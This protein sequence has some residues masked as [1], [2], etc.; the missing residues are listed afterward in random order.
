MGPYSAGHTDRIG[1][2]RCFS[3]QRDRLSAKEH[4]HGLDPFANRTPGKRAVSDCD[5][6]FGVAIQ[7]KPAAVENLASRSARAA[8]AVWNHDAEKSACQSRRSAFHRLR[9]RRG[10]ALGE[11][12]AIALV[13]MYRGN[14]AFGSLGDLATTFGYVGFTPNNG[15]G[16]ERPGCLLSATKRHSH[17]ANCGL[18]DHFV[19]A[20]E[21]RWRYG[22]AD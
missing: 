20:G 6:G 8:L 11:I 2:C 16:A 19:G 7:Q 21:K 22:Q 17:A 5:S 4:R 13:P 1:N 12:G 9:A 14:V 10:K 18:F 15:H 3:Y